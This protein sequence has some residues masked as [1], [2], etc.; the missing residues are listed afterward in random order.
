MITLSHVERVGK[1]EVSPG[2]LKPDLD[3]DRGEVN[4]LVIACLSMLP[5][6]KQLLVSDRHSSGGSLHF[7][8]AN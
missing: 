6:P 5:N 4:L 7:C 8:S 3:E 1:D 2:L